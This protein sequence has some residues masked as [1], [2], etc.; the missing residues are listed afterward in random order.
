MAIERLYLQTDEPKLFDRPI[1][2]MQKSI[3]KRLLFMNHVFGRCERLIKAVDG[4]K[5]Y[6]PN[7]YKGGD[8]YELLT[9]DN[10]DLGNYCFFV[11]DEPEV[12]VSNFGISGR[13]KAPFSLV[14]WVDLRTIEEKD[15]RNVY[16]LELKVLDA[17]ASPGVLRNGG[18]E[19]TRVYH[20]AENVF[21]GFTMDEVDNQYLMSPFT[22]LRIE[23]EIW[24]DED[25][26]V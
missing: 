9:P 17:V 4:R 21:A 24:V 13:M 16:D 2:D 25:C 8:E 1:Q 15:V 10:A 20:R 6:T 23:M 11:P 22:G 19:V 26:V 18:M 3:A 12:M 5:Y 14:V 7:V